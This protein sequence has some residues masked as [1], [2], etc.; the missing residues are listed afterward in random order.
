[1]DPSPKEA[2]L[3]PIIAVFFPLVALA[4]NVVVQVLV[5]RSSRGAKLLQ[6]AVIAFLAGLG[7]LVTME[8]LGVG[9]DLHREGLLASLAVHLV[10][11][12]ALCYC[13]FH[14]VNLGQCSIRIR[15]YAEIAA[16][17]G[18]LSRTEL[19]RDYSDTTLRE[20][21]LQRLQDAG[22]IVLRDGRFFIGHRRLVPAARI[23]FA[24]KK[25]LLSRT[26]EFS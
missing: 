17:P 6:S 24:A 5:F 23:I 11:Y 22:N 10:T 9:R 20:S 26:S 19:E 3:L 21:R 16:A 4:I 2:E 12:T 25:I 1:M 8:L 15:I 13:Y 18:G 14:F 7:A